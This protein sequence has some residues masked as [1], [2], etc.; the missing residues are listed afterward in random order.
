MKN[1]IEFYDGLNTYAPGWQETMP[2]CEAEIRGRSTTAQE[3]AEE[4]WEQYR[5]NADFRW[6][7]DFIT[8]G[9][10]VLVA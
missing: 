2:A 4:A 3:W 1:R 8:R 9:G 7:F 10:G 5:V 6:V